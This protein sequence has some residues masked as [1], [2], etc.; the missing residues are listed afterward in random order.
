[1]GEK[2]RV[3]KLFAGKLESVMIS[4]G[5]RYSKDFTPNHDLSEGIKKS[6]VALHLDFRTGPTEGLSDRAQRPHSV[7]AIG[8]PVFVERKLSPLPIAPLE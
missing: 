8:Q 3:E 2:D 7:V 4:S 1:M 5:A 6:S